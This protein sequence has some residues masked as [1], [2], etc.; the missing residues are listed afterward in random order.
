MSEASAT[1]G[2]AARLAAARRIDAIANRFED[3]WKAGQRPRIEDFVAAVPESEQ[4]ALLRELITL[5]LDYRR[6]LG[7]APQPEDYHPRFPAADPQWLTDVIATEPVRTG[8]LNN[9]ARLCSRCTFVAMP[10]ETPVFPVC[11]L[12]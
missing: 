9:R 2:A 6:R 1:R 4:A 11:S 5:D 12:I 7:E 3:A 10:P 8:P